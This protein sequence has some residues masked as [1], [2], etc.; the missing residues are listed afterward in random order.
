MGQGKEHKKRDIVAARSAILQAA[1]TI[2]AREGF[3]GAR[4]DQ[5]AEASG[6][7]KTLLFHYFG[8]KAGL[9]QAVMQRVR[10]QIGEQLERKLAPFVEN[11]FVTL[12][13]RL[14]QG[15][16]ET[17]IS[18]YFD[19]LVE[20]P[21]ILRILGWEIGDQWKTFLAQPAPA[22]EARQ[23]AAALAFLRRAQQA[24]FIRAEINVQALLASM[25]VLSLVHLLSLPRSQQILEMMGDTWDQELVHLKQ[26][27]LHL[28]LDGALPHP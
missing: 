12:D 24:G 22:Q 25:G 23:L 6:Y 4:V 1:E 10:H 27:I 19:F 2:F 28:L 20:H 9:Y 14:V 26:H 21:H 7:T 17:F 8:D 16:L 5:I 18:W 3:D 11:Q 15:F 13:A